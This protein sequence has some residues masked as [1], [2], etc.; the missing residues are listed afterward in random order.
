MQ[1]GWYVVSNTKCVNF[2]ESGVVLKVHTNSYQIT[3]KITN[4]TTPITNDGNK[5]SQ[6]PLLS[7]N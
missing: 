4:L 1:S 5:C 7:D 3:N 6:L 2:D